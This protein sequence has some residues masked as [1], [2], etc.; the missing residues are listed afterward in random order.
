MFFH[1]PDWELALFTWIN[2][3]I[4]NGLLDVLMPLLSSSAFL[5][6]ASI[7]LMAAGMKFRRVTATMIV[8]VALCVGISDQV[9]YHIKESI[10]RVRPYQSLPGTRY[11][12]S[13]VWKTLPADFSPQKRTGSSFPSSHA[14]NAAAAATFLYAAL[15]R[16]SLWAIPVAI[17][18]S[19]IY[20]GKH[21]PTDV[22]AAWAVGLAVGGV[23][24]TLYPALCSRL[25]SRWMRNKLR[26]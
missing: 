1:T 14:S 3:D 2:Q 18:F 19:R 9:C 25:R 17:G 16:K 6:A 26:T 23:F 5:W 7:A 20:V 4:Q 13:G 11:Q 8:G 22:L 12:D 24:V 21:F 15:R 10:G